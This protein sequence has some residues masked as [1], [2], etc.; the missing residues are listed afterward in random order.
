M[1][2]YSVVLS[3]TAQ[4]DFIGVIDHINTLPAEEA[5]QSMDSITENAKTLSK[6]PASCPYTKDSQL[7]LRGYR[8]LA[9]GDYLFFFVVS[10][11]TVEVR[12]V[13]SAKRQYERLV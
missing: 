4:R 1:E 12:R 7:R 3:P 13:L 11:I 6:S 9:A 5:V 2:N 10:G 8:V